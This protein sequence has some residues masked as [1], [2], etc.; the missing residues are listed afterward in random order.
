MKKAAFC[1][2]A[3]WTGTVCLCGTGW[4]QA[5]A[6]LPDFA[7]DAVGMVPVPGGEAVINMMVTNADFVKFKPTHTFTQDQSFGPAVMTEQEGRDYAAWMHRQI[8]VDFVWRPMPK[9]K[10]RGVLINMATGF[11]LDPDV[12]TSAE[13]DLPENMVYVPEGTFV[14]GSEMGDE[15]EAPQHQI[16]A[17]PFYIDKYEVGNAEFKAEFPDYTYPEGH[18][19]MPAVV[20]WEQATAFAEKVGKRLPTEAEWE[21]AA[22][23][24]DG[25]TFPWGE[26]YDPSFL[27][28]D[29]TDP[30]G[31]APARPESPY[32]CVDMAGGVW[33]WTADWYNAYPG[34]PAEKEEF[35]EKYK[36][37]RGGATF[38]DIAM[39]RT[40]HR[41][42]L[43]PD[44]T[45]HLRVGFRCVRDAR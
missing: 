21:K 29:E 37:I 28:W 5:P 16:G 14:M 9:S 43:P 26:S 40:T 34:S 4:A 24:T 13:P 41:Y 1:V 30:R 20:T 33:E 6:D 22:R 42:Y 7:Q 38:N 2:V 25:R 27:V 44:T 19:N 32:G 12:N 31:S 10:D 15:D 8:G 17:G 11:V 45:G 36:V 23:G 18:D 35:G 3:L 39:C